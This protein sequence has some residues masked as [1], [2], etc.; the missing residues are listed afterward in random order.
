RGGDRSRAQ[1]ESPALAEGWSPPTEGP[2]A[3]LGSR[4]RGQLLQRPAASKR[5]EDPQRLAQAALLQAREELDLRRPQV[6]AQGRRLP[7][8]RVARLRAA[9][10]G[11]LRPDA[12]LEK[13]PDPRLSPA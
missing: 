3:G 9:G 13:L 7:V 2:E 4:R 1:A 5:R 6:Q 10:S 12:R 8:V 11:R